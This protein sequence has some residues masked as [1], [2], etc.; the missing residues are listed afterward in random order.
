MG[1][2]GNKVE[3][4]AGFANLDTMQHTPSNPLLLFPLLYAH[5]ANFFLPSSTLM[6][7]QKVSKSCFFASNNK[8]PSKYRRSPDNTD[9]GESKIPC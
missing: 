1:Q 3:G 2:L 7:R 9:F 6:G 8:R 5:T 4:V